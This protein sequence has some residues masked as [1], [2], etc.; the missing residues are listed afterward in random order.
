MQLLSQQLHVLLFHEPL[1][2]P[3]ASSQ[4]QQL[5]YLAG[6]ALLSSAVLLPEILRNLIK[7]MSNNKFIPMGEGKII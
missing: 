4:L 5:P 1:L 3:C 2:L 7:T 6:L